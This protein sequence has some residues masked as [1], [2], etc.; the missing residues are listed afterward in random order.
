MHATFFDADH[1]TVYFMACMRF[2]VCAV[3]CQLSGDQQGHKGI[4]LGHFQ[5]KVV[6][7]CQ[8]DQKVSFTQNCSAEGCMQIDIHDTTVWQLSCGTSL[9]RYINMQGKRSYTNKLNF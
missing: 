5:V 4:F 3:L 9:M 6:T 1:A 7:Q 2:C 8:E